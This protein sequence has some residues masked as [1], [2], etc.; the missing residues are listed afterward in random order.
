[1][2]RFETTLLVKGNA[3]LPFVAHLLAQARPI[4]AEIRTDTRVG[5]NAEIIPEQEPVDVAHSY[6]K[7]SRA[8]RLP[9]MFD[10][11]LAE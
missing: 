3:A 6:P 1:L 10:S 7:V 2:G 4:E 9:A 5:P 8:R 11:W